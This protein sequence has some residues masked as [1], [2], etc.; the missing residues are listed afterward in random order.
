VSL[1]IGFKTD[2][3]HKR[4]NNEDSYAVLRR[5]ELDKALD[6]LFVIADGMG[7]GRH[8]DVASGL[9]AQTVPET[10]QEFLFEFER[11]NGNGALDP[12]R[13]LRDALIRVNG[14][15]W[16][17]GVERS[18]LRGMGTTC[19][20]AIVKDNLLTIGNIGDSRAYLLREGKLSQIT[21]D[22]SEVWQQV[23]AGNMTREQ[24]RHS[25]HRNSITRAIGLKP[26]VTPDVEQ[27]T[28]EEGD[29]VLL[30][31][32]GLTTEVSDTEIARILA[33]VPDAQEVCDRLVA[34]ALRH[35]G[36]D[37]VTVVVLRYGVFTPIALPDPLPAEEEDLP[38]DPSAEWRKAGRRE[39]VPV[40]FARD[41]DDDYGDDEAYEQR[42]RSSRR[43]SAEGSAS[44]RT[45]GS[46]NLLGALVIILLLVA[47]A[48]AAALTIALKHRVI[49]AAPI[50]VA[51]SDVKPPP[52]LTSGPLE[53]YPPSMVIDQPVLSSF[54]TMDSE[55]NVYVISAKNGSLLKVDRKR[56]VTPITPARTRLHKPD[57]LS[58]DT[59]QP[60]EPLYTAFD[61]SGYRY[62]SDRVFKCIDKFQGNTRVDQI[63]KGRLNHPASLVVDDTG[64]LF[65]IDG[66]S[67]YRIDAFPPPTDHPNPVNAQ[68]APQ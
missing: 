4:E 2:V 55:G 8:G 61:P 14:R 64:T 63:A 38:T 35:G 50:V 46:S 62:Q 53:Y 42:P 65:V 43:R 24:A 67:L 36:S 17:R 48:E 54:L 58:S 52:P 10:I 18:E 23:K 22:H 33:T 68:D 31:T 39:P 32:D 19:V 20:A 21:E 45:P 12:S 11:S 3:G 66:N 41:D 27:F 51:Q 6:G 34:T 37:N 25:K 28:L 13:L 56:N 57:D 49:T 5:E 60:F 59:S 26:D 15:V 44:V 29:T 1:S 7:G 9:V 30:C 47:I 40:A 16:M